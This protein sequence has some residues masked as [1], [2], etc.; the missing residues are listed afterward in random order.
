[1]TRS[2]R[3]GTRLRDTHM[4]LSHRN[5]DMEKMCLSAHCAAVEWLEYGFSLA[6]SPRILA[7][8]GVKPNFLK[9]SSPFFSLIQFYNCLYFG[10]FGSRFLLSFTNIGRVTRENVVF[11]LFTLLYFSKSEGNIW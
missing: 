10:R 9:F 2:Y 8:K 4:F 11:L 7:F 5:A 1:M 6:I 3:P